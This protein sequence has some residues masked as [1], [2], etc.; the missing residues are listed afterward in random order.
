MTTTVEE[1]VDLAR[2]EHGSYGPEHLMMQ[3]AWALKR[4]EGEPVFTA[5]ENAGVRKKELIAR[6]ACSLRRQ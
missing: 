2:K 6:A 1:L 3:A 4:I 5:A